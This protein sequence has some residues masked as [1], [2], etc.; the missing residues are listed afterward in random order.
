MSADGRSVDFFS[1][2]APGSSD[3]TPARDVVQ[4]GDESDVDFFESPAKRETTR[5]DSKRDSKPD[6]DDTDDKPGTTDHRRA[7]EDEP[8][9]V[10]ED[11]EGEGDDDEEEELKTKKDSKKQE[12]K[13]DKE[14]D[15]DALEEGEQV[16]QED[17]PKKKRKGLKFKLG[18]EV[19]TVPHDGVI[20]LNAGG[21]EIEVT[22][23]DL[24]QSFASKKEMNRIRGENDKVLREAKRIDAEAKV[25]EQE[26]LQFAREFA[27]KVKKKENVIAAVADLF[28]P[29]LADGTSGLD[30]VRQI[31][32]GILE[33]AEHWLSLTEE[34]RRNLDLQEELQ[35][36]RSKRT[37]IEESQ[38]KVVRSQELMQQME[39]AGRAFGVPD[40][41][42]FLDTQAE[43]TEL[44]KS[45][46]T[47]VF[48]DLKEITPNHIGGFYAMKSVIKE[49]YPKALEDPEVV[50][51][52]FDIAVN[53]N[54]TREELLEVVRT[55]FGING[56]QASEASSGTNGKHATNGKLSFKPRVEKA[57][58]K[59]KTKENLFL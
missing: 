12:K 58:G 50:G 39:K 2:S 44:A 53:F 7:G 36:E 57:D 18:D 38:K 8:D 51:R 34:Q 27:E 43:L 31:R 4:R 40:G 48:R 35:Y 10:D 19:I 32:A 59:A 56:S 20:T 54:P 46:K 42:T 3:S 16:L 25:K 30:L 21:E 47:S 26:M 5:K 23:H 37:R 17:E 49:V 55:H 14:K 22:A 1:D 33:N 24:R 15:E 6:S 29:F 52:F 28:D 41:K 11:E 13:E 45:K 9:D